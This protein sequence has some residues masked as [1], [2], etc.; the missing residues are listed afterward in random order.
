MSRLLIIL[1]LLCVVSVATAQQRQLSGTVSNSDGEPLGG[2][3]VKVMS[4]KRIRTF[5]RT[6]GSG[7]YLIKIPE[8]D[9]LSLR[10]ERMSSV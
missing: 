10:F 4:G 2:V 9:S 3:A 1:W 7:D 8:G 5:T 6:S